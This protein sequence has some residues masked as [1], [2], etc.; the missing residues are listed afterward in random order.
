MPTQNGP[1]PVS[2]SPTIGGWLDP[3]R[4]TISR[5]MRVDR[6][7]DGFIAPRA[8]VAGLR[9][10]DFVSACPKRRAYNSHYVTYLSA[11]RPFNAEVVSHTRFT[12]ENEPNA[13]I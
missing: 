5:S 8:G 12:I 6:H 11:A 1:K 10:L 2:Q 9:S 7:K 3:E 13:C 4:G